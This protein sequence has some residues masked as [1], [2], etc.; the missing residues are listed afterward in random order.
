MPDPRSNPLAD[1]ETSIALLAD[2]AWLV[3]RLEAPDRARCVAMM[4][5]Q[6]GLISGLL[7]AAQTP[8]AERPIASSTKFSQWSES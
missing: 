8:E 5:R 7:S 1:L 6:T 4:V 3:T 2:L